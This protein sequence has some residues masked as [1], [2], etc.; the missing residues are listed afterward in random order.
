MSSEWLD[1]Y[2]VV[3]KQKNRYVSCTIGLRKPR[4]YKVYAIGHVTK[5]SPGYLPYISTRIRA[6]GPLMV[7]QHKDSAL[8]YIE[9][10]WYDGSFDFEVKLFRCRYIPSMDT[11]CWLPGY[12]RR[13]I[14]HIYIPDERFADAVELIEEVTEDEAD[15]DQTERERALENHWDSREHHTEM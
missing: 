3:R 12:R 14:C 11:Y 7:F 5:R 1:G 15:D 13:N 10:H 9:K 2:K 8:R 4:G 6:Y